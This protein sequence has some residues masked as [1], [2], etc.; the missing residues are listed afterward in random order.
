ML[1]FFF[2]STID[3]L[4][5]TYT[6]VVF[7]HLDHLALSLLFKKAIDVLQAIE[8]NKTLYTVN[9]AIEKENDWNFL[10]IVQTYVMLRNILQIQT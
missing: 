3:F 6:G 7:V 5:I 1:N 2:I 10:M 9:S 4:Y 8:I